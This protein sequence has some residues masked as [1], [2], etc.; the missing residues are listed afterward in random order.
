LKRSLT[1]REGEA[2]AAA[3]QSSRKPLLGAIS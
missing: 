1:F 3:L 2:P